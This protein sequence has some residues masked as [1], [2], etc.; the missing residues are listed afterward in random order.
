MS[1]LNLNFVQTCADDLI[2]NIA[3]YCPLLTRLELRMCHKVTDIGID[4]L[5]QKC[6]KL[7]QL[8]IGGS[9]VSQSK[10]KELVSNG[11]YVF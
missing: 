2:R 5:L 7:S 9:S 1:S 10:I 4:I 3:S 8:I 6:S 11:L